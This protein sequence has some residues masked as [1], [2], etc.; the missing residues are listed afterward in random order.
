M[1]FGRGDLEDFSLKGYDIAAHSIVELKDSSYSLLF[2]GASKERQDKVAENLLQTGISKNRLIVKSFV[3]DRQKLR[4]LF[5]AVDLAIMPSRTE[6]FG[7]I[8]L[9]AMSAGLLILVS[10]NSGFGKT[11]RILPMGE[12]FVID[13][14]DP[15][16]W[17]K[18]VAAI[19]QKSRTQR[20][21]KIQRLRRSYDERFS[22]EGQCQALGDRMWKMVYG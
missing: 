16:E 22:W 15:K 8:A 9:E 5:C 13:S 3:T 19:R 12:S 11:L 7:L 1:T 2:V 17:T 6:G 10:G 21:E 20:L 18:A 14:D 4:E